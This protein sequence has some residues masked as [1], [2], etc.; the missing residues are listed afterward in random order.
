MI[1]VGNPNRFP[2][3]ITVNSLPVQN[4]STT[5]RESIFFSNISKALCQASWA[6]E[7]ETTPA[8]ETEESPA[9]E[10]ATEESPAAEAEEEPAAEATEEAAS[11]SSDDSESEEEK[12]E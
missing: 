5:T 2:S 1:A 9:A 3:T 8:A 7:T 6:L 11:E 4:G 10:E 12:S